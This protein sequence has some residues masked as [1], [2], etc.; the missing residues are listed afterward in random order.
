MP[1]RSRAAFYHIVARLP[2]KLWRTWQTVQGAQLRA[3]GVADT[4]RLL[5]AQM[6]VQDRCQSYHLRR[7]LLNFYYAVSV[8][9]P[10]FYSVANTGASVPSTVSSASIRR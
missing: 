6:S 10:P 1:E 9:L 4:A 5:L 7:T 8:E 2:I 3:G